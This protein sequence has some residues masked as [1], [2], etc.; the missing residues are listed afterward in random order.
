MYI[1]KL[2]CRFFYYMYILI[3]KSVKNFEIWE[4]ILLMFLLMWMWKICQQF[5]MNF[6]S[7]YVSD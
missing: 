5:D 4:M 7:R 6:N 1:N 2:F 3:L